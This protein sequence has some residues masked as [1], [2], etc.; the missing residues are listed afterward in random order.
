MCVSVCVCGVS[1]FRD[2]SKSA[3]QSC[4]TLDYRKR[5]IGSGSFTESDLRLKV[6]YAFSP[7]CI[8][9]KCVCVCVCRGFHFRVASKSSFTIIS[10]AKCV[11]GGENAQD[12]LSRRSLS[13]K[14][15]LIW[16]LFCGKWLE[17]RM[18]MHL[19]HP[20]LSGKHTWDVY[21][22]IYMSLSAKEPHN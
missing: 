11:Q 3:L 16:G 18:P 12:A 8:T 14:E 5:P 17:L 2:A 6:F 9:E 22:Y 10:L 7:P 20:V 13:A 15:P 1:H 19:R 21:S 4:C